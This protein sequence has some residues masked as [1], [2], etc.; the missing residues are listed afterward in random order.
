MLAAIM[1]EAEI[2][3]SANPVAFSD[4]YVGEQIGLFVTNG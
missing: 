1:D 3:F 4:F 2:E